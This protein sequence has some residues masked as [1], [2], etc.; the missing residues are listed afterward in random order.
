MSIATRQ[1]SVTTSATRLDDSSN[2]PLRYGVLVRN[3]GTA[4]VY[5]GTAAVAAG[6]GYQLDPGEAVSMDLTTFDGGLYGIAASGSHT[7][8][9]LQQGS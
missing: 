2:P 1:V 6:T 4:A 3:R 5:V 9:V 7:C 8:H